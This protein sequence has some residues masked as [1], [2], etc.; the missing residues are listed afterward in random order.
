M[1]V[2]RELLPP[3]TPLHLMAHPGE[4]ALHRLRGHP[5]P[6]SLLN[7]LPPPPPPPSPSPPPPP[8][9][10]P[11]PYTATGTTSEF[12]AR[13]G[14]LTLLPLLQLYTFL[15]GYGHLEEEAAFY[16]VLLVD[17][18]CLLHLLLFSLGVD[19]GFSFPRFGST[20]YFHPPH[21][22]STSNIHLLPSSPP[23][24][25]SLHL[26]PSPGW[27]TRPCGPPWCGRRGCRCSTT[28]RW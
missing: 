5:P 20:L 4:E 1:E 23:S 18:T 17:P 2:H 22:P 6:P 25:T 19:T 13:E 14:L 7:H 27:V 16:T 12:L 10:H 9:P 24:T 11:S 8:H 15:N 28:A 3:Y 26:L 21:P